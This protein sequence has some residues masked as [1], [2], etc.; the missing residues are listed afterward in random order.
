VFFIKHKSE[1]KEYLQGF[2]ERCE[3][4]LPHGVQTL[5][6]DNGLEFVNR[7]VK[8]LPRSYGVRHEKTVAYSP[9]QNGAAEREN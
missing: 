3:K 9:E 4:I 7:E 8:E 6:T 5:R 1:I 2:L